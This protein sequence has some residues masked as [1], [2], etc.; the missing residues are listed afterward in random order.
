VA[1]FGQRSAIAVITLLAID[2]E[3]GR[4]QLSTILT[5]ADAGMRV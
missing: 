3:M 1:A 4:M 2:A 5:I